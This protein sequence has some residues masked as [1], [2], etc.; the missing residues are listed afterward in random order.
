MAEPFEIAGR[1]H[2]AA[3]ATPNF[4]TAVVTNNTDPENLGRVKVQYPWSS[5]SNESEWARIAT[6]MAGAER[7]S[8][9][10]PE[11]GDE[12]LVCFL[13]GDVESPVVVGALWNQGDTPP[14]QNSDGANNI[15]MIQ[16]RS[17][18]KIVFDDSDD[19]GAEKLELLSASGHRV[20]L[21]DA[22]G[23]GKITIEDNGGGR[24]EF[25]AVAQKISIRTNLE[26]TMEATN[27]TINASGVLTLQ[28]GVVRIN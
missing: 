12:V 7:G 6:M 27:I 1:S 5:E 24:I 11:V 2:G 13:N 23:A 9:F 8:Y 21:D 4:T 25:D 26:V 3:A 19:S 10:I 14:A 22:T 15:R 28:G 16:S 18:H 20:T 17:G